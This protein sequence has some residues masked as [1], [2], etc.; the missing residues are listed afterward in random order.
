VRSKPELNLSR[1]QRDN[2]FEDWR[3]QQVAKLRIEMLKTR[4]N[5]IAAD[6]ER[7]KLFGGKQGGWA[8][9]CACGVML[10]DA[11]DI[12][13]MIDHRPHMIAAGIMASA[14]FID[15]RASK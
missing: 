12:Q 14:N 11:S 4:A 13:T 8:L 5:L 10:E 15:G 6:R 7:R 1:E 9:L 2:L 3:R